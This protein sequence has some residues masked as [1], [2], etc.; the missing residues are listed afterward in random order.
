MPPTRD[1]IPAPYFGEPPPGWNDWLHLTNVEHW[2]GTPHLDEEELHE[3]LR[4]M[5]FRTFPENA[6]QENTI[7]PPLT[8]EQVAL[9]RATLTATADVNPAYTL[10]HLTGRGAATW[11]AVKDTTTAPVE[12][13]P[14]H[15][16]RAH[17]LVFEEV[18][19]QLL[20]AGFTVKLHAHGLFGLGD[21]H[22][23]IL[24]LG[25]PGNITVPNG[26]EFVIAYR[27][28]HDQTYAAQGNLGYYIP[29]VRT[30]QNVD[31]GTN[32]L[33]A[34]VIW[35]GGKITFSRR[36][37][38][39]FTQNFGQRVLEMVGRLNQGMSDMAQRLNV[40]TDL[41]FPDDKTF[42]DIVVK[43]FRENVLPGSRFREFFTHWDALRITF[44]AN[45]HNVVLSLARVEA[46]HPAPMEQA[47][48]HTRLV[49]LL[50]N[51]AD[52][53]IDD[54]LAEQRAAANPPNAGIAYTINTPA[55]PAG[56]EA[57]GGFIIPLGTEVTG[58]EGAQALRPIL[59]RNYLHCYSRTGSK[60]KRCR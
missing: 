48:R 31:E 35:I 45:L 12:L 51:L 60:G 20:E 53:L 1:L 28:S 5:Y 15:R 56:E 26:L 24:L 6:P 9:T 58:A 30:L 32:P 46:A 16:P 36:H 57:R 23:A 33:P 34:A 4:R 17:S 11:Q 27:N 52:K 41:Q 13:G 7:M 3:M 8:P 22:Y 39:H 59:R 25:P 54:V 40:Y 47:D 18:V 10:H 21:R 2:L 50:D 55:T 38:T 14:R 19:T 37:T 42:H 29:E 43:M 44:G 49:A